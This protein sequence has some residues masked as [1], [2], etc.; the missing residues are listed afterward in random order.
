MWGP[1]GISLAPQI[2]KSRTLSKVFRP[3]ANTF[4][5]ASGHRQL[6]LKYDDLRVFFSLVWRPVYIS[7]VQCVVIV[8]RDDVAKVCFDTTT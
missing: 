3:F 4:V 6:G 8:E 7:D 5:K 1:F 2:Q